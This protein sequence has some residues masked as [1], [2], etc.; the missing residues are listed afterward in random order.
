MKVRTIMKCMLAVVLLCMSFT[1]MMAQKKIDKLFDE[2]EKRDDV[3]VNSVTK[4]DPKT[5]QIIS[6]VKSLSLKN[7]KVG[8]LLIEAFEKDEEYAETAIKDMP[9]GRR[10][11]LRV[12]FTFIFRTSDGRQCTYTL[13]TQEDGT[14]TATRIIKPIKNDGRNVSYILDDDFNVQIQELV[15]STDELGCLITN[16]ERLNAI[17]KAVKERTAKLKNKKETLIFEGDVWMDGKKMKKGTYNMNGR[18][19]IVQ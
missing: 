13:T 2:L 6:M 14:V 15:A 11:P 9:K 16:D 1:P 7:I 19:V 3:A 10:T 12:N 18:K 4:R 8:R 17:N 5:R